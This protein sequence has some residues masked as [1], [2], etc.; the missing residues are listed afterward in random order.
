[1]KP[2][3]SHTFKG[4]IQLNSPRFILD[5]Q[6]EKTNRENS[7]FLLVWTEAGT[8]LKLYHKTEEALINDH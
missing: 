1:M 2:A 3:V 6:K 8:N 4:F 5:H 7:I